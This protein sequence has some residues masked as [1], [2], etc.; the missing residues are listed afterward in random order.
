MSAWLWFMVG[1]WFVAFLGTMYS[2]GM[3]AAW[4]LYGKEEE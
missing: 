4:M 3:L 1:L 2:L